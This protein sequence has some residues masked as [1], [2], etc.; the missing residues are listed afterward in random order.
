MPDISK[1]N[2]WDF[3][4]LLLP[5]LVLG[6]AFHLA[7]H[8]KLKPLTKDDLAV[9]PVFALL[10]G[11]F[12][13]ANGYALQTGQSVFALEPRQLLWL[14]VGVPGLFGLLA[15]ALLRAEAPRRLCEGLGIPFPADPPPIRSAWMAV[16]PKIEVGQY[17]MIVLDDGTIYRALVTE[18]SDFS[19]D[20]TR[21]DL[22]LG[23]VF[24]GEDW[25]PVSPQRSV[26]I[27]GD[28]IRSIEIF[29]AQN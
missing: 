15:G 19:S 4:V 29:T 13:W 2:P 11:V 28:R 5:G 16:A 6:Q 26:Y 9:Y 25:S 7:R 27:P 8:W 3:V 24:Q 20:P 17:L 1:L 12:L 23:Q 10:Y 22:H 21:I 14:Y 18:D